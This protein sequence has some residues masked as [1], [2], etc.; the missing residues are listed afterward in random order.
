MAENIAE[1]HLQGL[2]DLIASHDR[3]VARIGRLEN[4]LIEIRQLAA[5]IVE[6]CDGEKPKEPVPMMHEIFMQSTEDM[7]LS[8]RAYN[9]LK[10]AGLQ[11]IGEVVRRQ[12]ADLLKIIR[13]RALNEIKAELERQG[14]K[15]GMTTSDI[16]AWKPPASHRPLF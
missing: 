1:S 6:I 4:R 16:L 12:E 9:L 10:N 2:K 14:L 3:L 13:R 11:S 7:E 5:N 8:V 15:F